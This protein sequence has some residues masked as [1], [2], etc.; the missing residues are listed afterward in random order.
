MAM[1]DQVSAALNISV[2]DQI[3]NTPGTLATPSNLVSA[4]A[5]AAACAGAVMP[6]AAAVLRAVSASRRQAE[7]GVLALTRAATCSGWPT[8]IQ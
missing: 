7:T 8:H 5:A 6:V 1:V 2:I 4:A 3:E